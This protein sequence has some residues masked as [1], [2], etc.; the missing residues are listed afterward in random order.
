[1]TDYV[2]AAQKSEKPSSTNKSWILTSTLPRA[3]RVPEILPP[4]H[5][6]SIAIE[7]TYTALY[8]FIIAVISLNGGS[9]G[10]QK[11]ERYLARMNADTYTPIERT[12]KFLQHLVKEGYLDRMR[13]NDGGEEIVEYM[14]GP[15]GK[16]E[17]GSGGVAGLAREVYGYGLGSIG[18]EGLTVEERKER[19]EFE[20]R[21]RRSLGIT[22]VREEDE[23]RDERANEIR[24]AAGV[25]R[26]SSRR[27]N[28][29]EEE[30]EEEEDDHD[31][32]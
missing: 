10:E 4:T 32:D 25:S 2:T 13:E 24:N 29:H 19:D 21:L 3:Y 26:R 27:A 11:L 18:E 30:S 15:R 20:A 12:D 28:A 9:L 5:A 6:P 7:S 14:V 31:S 23:E 1:M 22:A 16:V 17:V 8:S